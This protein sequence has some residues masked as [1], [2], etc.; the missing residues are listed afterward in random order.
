[1]NSIQ[2]NDI[3]KGD[4]GYLKNG[5]KFEM[6]DN[7]KGNIRMAKVHGIETE[8]GS[9][10]AHEIAFIQNQDGDDVPVDASRYQ[11]QTTMIQ[12]LGF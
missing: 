2:P 10:Y 1:M 11:K 8:I 3:K 6:M 4:L 7:K 12:N 9:I 5:W